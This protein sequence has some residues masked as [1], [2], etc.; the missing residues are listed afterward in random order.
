MK[1]IINIIY[2]NICINIIY[3]IYIIHIIQI[4]FSHNSFKFFNIIILGKFNIIK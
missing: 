1:T 4:V 2:I 3:T